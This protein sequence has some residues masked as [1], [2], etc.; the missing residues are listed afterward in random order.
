M[1]F[2]EMRNNPGMPMPGRMVDM[3]TGRRRERAHMPVRV[4]HMVICTRRRETGTAYRR[5]AR[6]VDTGPA[7]AD[8]EMSTGLYTRPTQCS[9]RQCGQKKIAGYTEGIHGKNRR[10]IQ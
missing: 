8:A 1:P 6:M 7:Y 3:H 9:Q 5:M 10:L 2:P 4:P